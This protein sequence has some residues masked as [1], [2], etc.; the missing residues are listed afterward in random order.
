MPN[1]PTPKEIMDEPMSFEGTPLVDEVIYWYEDGYRDAVKAKL[2]DHEKFKYLAN[3]VGVMNS[4]TPCFINGGHQSNPRVRIGGPARYDKE[5]G[6]IWLGDK[7]SIIT[8]M[9]E[10]AHFKFDADEKFACRFSYWLFKA[11]FPKLL[12]NLEWKGH[13]LVRK[14]KKV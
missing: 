4:N 8:T 5:S 3:L 2:S 10:F 14:E 13:L 9:H 1:Y 7:P 6:T 12:E 11:C